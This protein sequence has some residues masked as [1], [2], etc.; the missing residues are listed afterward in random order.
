MTKLKN[1]P[2]SIFE[3]LVQYK[4]DMAHVIESVFNSLPN[5]KISD[6]SKLKAFAYDKN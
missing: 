6:L 1:F 5:D 4:I 3:T 2:L